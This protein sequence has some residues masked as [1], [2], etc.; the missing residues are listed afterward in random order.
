[1][2]RMQII[3]LIQSVAKAPDAFDRLETALSDL[4]RAQLSESLIVCGII[5]ERFAHDS[6]EEKLWAKY[7]DILLA[8]SLSFMGI[9]A[10]VLRTRGNSADV[11][12]QA[13]DY[14]IVGDAKAFRLSRTA[15]NQK[16]FKVASLD[17]WRRSDTF[18]CLVSPLYQYPVKSSQIYEQAERRNV[19]L[20]S[21]LHLRFMLDHQPRTS[22]LNLWQFPRTIVPSQNSQVYWKTLDEILLDL[23][24]SKLDDLT[25]YKQAEID[26]T[27]QMGAEE[28]DYWE[29]V[30]SSYQQL[31]K[32]EA[33]QQLIK[34]EKIEEKIKTIRQ[35]ISR[36]LML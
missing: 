31:T 19:V 15:K 25:A 23:T 30:I 18:A 10:Q 36:E 16:D 4:S 32:A 27:R 35:A 29:S 34:A 12:G 24:G 7:C 8:K 21:Y 28:V 11:F 2:K 26:Y 22:L 9:P 3:Q 5:P 33:V 6:S 13:E 20:L 17:A 1:M 14:T